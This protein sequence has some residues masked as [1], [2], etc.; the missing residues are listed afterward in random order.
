M[1]REFDSHLGLEQIDV[2][3]QKLILRTISSDNVKNV[4]DLAILRSLNTFYNRKFHYIAGL[5]PCL[6]HIQYLNR[7]LWYDEAAVVD[8]AI[9][10]N[11]LHGRVG[12]D[13]LQTIPLGYFLLVKFFAELPMG[14]LFLRIISLSALFGSLSIFAFVLNNFRVRKI[15]IFLFT[16]FVALGPFIVNY[17]TMVKPYMFDLLFT[18]LALLV[19]TKEGRHKSIYWLML[20]PLVSSTFLFFSAAIMI[21]QMVRSKGRDTKLLV[22]FIATLFTTYALNN[23]LV[24]SVF[25]MYYFPDK[26]MLSFWNIKSAFYQYSSIFARFIDANQQD[27]LLGRL[28]ALAAILTIGLIAGFIVRSDLVTDIKVL[29]LGAIF[30]I[31]SLIVFSANFAMFFPIS[32]RLNF[33]LISLFI[34]FTIL[35][36]SKFNKLMRSAILTLIASFIVF[37]FTTAQITEFGINSNFLA[38]NTSSNKSIWTD[39]LSGPSTRI[40]FSNQNQGRIQTSLAVTDWGEITICPQSF[41]R[42]TVGDMLVVYIPESIS[43][44]PILNNSVDLVDYSLKIAIYRVTKNSVFYSSEYYKNEFFCRYRNVNP[45]YPLG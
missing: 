13:W 9:R 11:I 15:S 44:K 16:S 41:G 1:G 19:I 14:L 30:L 18:A 12:L 27:V 21:F 3:T 7:N 40:F 39:L 33:P 35:S 31:H 5:V 28:E 29:N 17:A 24:V 22:L 20:A 42:P 36:I 38:R 25:K 34:F 10:Y 37:F 6:W 8:N 23:H 2:I 43:Q 45:N 4:G 26:P 32:V